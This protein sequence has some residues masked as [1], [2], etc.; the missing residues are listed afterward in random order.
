MRSWHVALFSALAL[1]LLA[2]GCADEDDQPVPAGS[3]GASGQ[4]GTR[5]V[6][7][8]FSARVGT[9][10]FACG[11]FYEGIGSSKTMVKPLDFRL[12]VHDLVLIRA[13]GERVPV[14]LAQDG[15]WQNGS[16]ALLDFEDGTGD[17]TEG[18]ADLHTAITGTVPD[19]DDYLNLSFK[20]GVP[21]DRNHLD[22]ATAPAPLNVP[23]MWWA[24]QGGYKYLKLDLNTP[25]NPAYYLHLG[26]TSCDGSPEAGFTCAYSNVPSFTVPYN[27][28]GGTVI[29]DVASLYDGV[30]LDVVNDTTKDP[31]PGCMSF[32]GD[33]QCPSVYG[34]LGLQFES[35][36]PAALPGS[37]VRVS[38]PE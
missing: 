2:A 13:N 23:A 30:D 20:I 3:S 37:F 15:A 12:Y 29:L 32:A 5:A 27:L 1:S 36:T 19:H 10:T 18:D 11:E 16:V 26:A 21:S 33:P 6:T 24:W 25:K 34:H 8:P 31:V 22:S 35:N 14:T 17:C 7:I 38:L 4:A 9:M 28:A